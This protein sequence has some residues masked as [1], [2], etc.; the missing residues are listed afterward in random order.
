MAA[1]VRPAAA[2]RSVTRQNVFRLVLVLAWL[3]AG[4][5]V[6]LHHTAD[7]STPPG[8]AQCQLCRINHFESA[9]VAGPVEIGLPDY[10]YAGS[11][12]PRSV[13]PTAPDTSSRSG[14]GPPSI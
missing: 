10:V 5:H 7:A 3:V 11:F 13:I 8:Q 12:I 9:V 6:A 1:M 2:R 14:R 4:F